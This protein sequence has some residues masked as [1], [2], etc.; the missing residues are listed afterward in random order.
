MLPIRGFDQTT[1]AQR[2]RLSQIFGDTSGG[3]VLIA[4]EKSKTERFTENG[5]PHSLFSAW[6]IGL[7]YSLGGLG[8]ASCL[9]S[10]LLADRIHC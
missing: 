2:S 8:L 3:L 7:I 4:W 10:G 6:G 9:A 5:K 1:L